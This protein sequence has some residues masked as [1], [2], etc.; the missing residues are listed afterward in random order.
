M[1]RLSELH[2]LKSHCDMFLIKIRVSYK[3][4]RLVTRIQG[5]IYYGKMD[6]LEELVA[7]RQKGRSLIP[8]SGEDSFTIV[9]I[10][11]YNVTHANA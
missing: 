9:E 6:A 4:C 11:S 1:I 5:L 3:Y 2:V 8:I 10:R 7:S